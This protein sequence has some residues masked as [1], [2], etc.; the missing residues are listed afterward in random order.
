MFCLT[1][2]R[3]IELCL[4]QERHAGQLFGLIDKNRAYLRQWLPW[5]DANR[6][7][8]DS[9]KF[10]KGALDQFAKN[11]GFQP[12]IFF[13]GQLAGMTGFHRFDWNNRATSLGYWL[14]LD[15]QGQGIVTGAVRYLVGYAFTDLKLNRVEIRC[16]VE[17]RKSCAIPKRLGFTREGVIRQ[18]E[19]LYDHYV[20]H[21]IYGML[22]GEW[23][24]VDPKA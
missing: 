6:S 12:A 8:D 11:Q 5:L 13:R 23:P 9:R 16:A 7:V 17:N 14:D 1:V 18:A 19:W 24:P 20:D 2:D 10:I 21:V 15:R 22:A 4:L 3:E